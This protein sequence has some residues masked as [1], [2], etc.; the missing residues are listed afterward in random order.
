MFAL[1]VEFLG[2]ECGMKN[3]VGHQIESEIQILLYHIERNGCRV[4]S[5]LGRQ[6][7]ADK[8]DRVSDVLQP[9][10]AWFLG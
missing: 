4:L 5:R 10:V 8:I 7:A 1:A 9:T 2:L 3:D 6:L